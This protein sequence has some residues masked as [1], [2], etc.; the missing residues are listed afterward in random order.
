M[1]NFNYTA[2]VKCVNG[3]NTWLELLFL[4]YP[5]TLSSD[6][7]A[8]SITGPSGLITN[9]LSEC[10]VYENNHHILY[11]VV[12][13]VPEL[14]TYNFS[15]TIGGET[16]NQSDVQTVNRTLPVVD[17]TVTTPAPGASIETDT[18]FSWSAVPDPGFPVY[19]GIQ[20]KTQ[21]ETD[22][23]AISERYIGD[24]QYAVNLSPGDYKWQVIVMD[25]ID[26]SNTN[27]RTHNHWENFTIV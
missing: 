20:I 22:D 8:F 23:F 6:I 18:T 1:A 17:M 9:D 12:D 14:G 10:Y 4:N 24:F 15:V 13:T 27:N 21:A 11:E 2:N 25:G 5:G 26:W 3:T 16:V 7:T 19:Y